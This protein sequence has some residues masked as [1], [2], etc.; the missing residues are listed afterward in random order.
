MDRHTSTA[1]SNFTFASTLLGLLLWSSAG[2][3]QSHAPAPEILNIGQGLPPLALTGPIAVGVF[4]NLESA[5]GQWAAQ[6]IQQITNLSPSIGELNR[7]DSKPEQN[8]AVGEALGDDTWTSPLPATHA[9]TSSV[10]LE[11]PIS[12]TGTG[13]METG[14][15]LAPNGAQESF[16]EFASDGDTGVYSA[17][18]EICLPESNGT[19]LKQVLPLDKHPIRCTTA[20]GVQGKHGY[21]YDVADKWPTVAYLNTDASKSSMSSVSGKLSIPVNLPAP[22]NSLR[23]EIELG[24]KDQN[25]GWN[26]KANQETFSNPTISTPYVRTYWGTVQNGSQ[27][28]PA[29]GPEYVNTR[30]AIQLPNITVLPAAFIQMKVLPYTILYRPPGDESQG[31]FQTTQSYGTQLTTGNNTAIDNTTAFMESMDIQNNTTVSALI[32][33]VQLQGDE[34]T[35]NTNASDTNGTIGTG[36]ITSNS[37]T[38]NRTWTLGTMTPD[39]SILPAAQYVTPNTCGA[40]YAAAGCTVAAAETFY[41]EPFWEDRIVLL[42]NP[43]T[44][45]WD[46]KAGTTMQLLGAADYDAVAIR[47]LFACAQN[48]GPTGWTLSNGVKLTPAECDDLLAL[49]PF[50]LEGQEY[51]P[52]QTNRGVAVGSGNYGSDPRC[53]ACAPLTVTFQDVFSYTSAQST[54]AAASYQTT[55]TSVVGFSWSAGMTLGY[56]YSEYGL[57]LGI[58]NGTTVKQ[59]YQSTTGTQMK[60]NYSASAVATSTNATTIT[61]MF[62]EDYDLDTPACQTNSTNCYTPQVNVYIDELFGSYMFVDPAAAANPLL[63]AIHRTPLT[64]AKFPVPWPIKGTSSGSSTP[65]GPPAGTQC[66]P[67]QRLCNK[68]TPPRCTTD[69]DC[70]VT[71]A[72]AK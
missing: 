3:S 16:P 5:Q 2:L 65:T 40:N 59:G 18:V 34:M 68:F 6:T 32:A 52:S 26:S 20:N 13:N 71:P 11:I 70:L 27:L 50:F 43:S 1:R 72:H 24:L 12:W 66:G 4:G 25:N 21:W 41:Q 44:A 45:V 42:L 19:T 39:P 8:L 69:A 53:P 67:N 58:S 63:Q 57:D 17:R 37:H 15:N 46:F 35:S 36:L 49:D 47:D 10:V 56:K 9:K 23:V 62:S 33:T 22:V 7:F 64:P 51:D 30:F 31:T 55:V 48:Q 28:S 38:V 61:G 54:S 60:V 14:L 29:G